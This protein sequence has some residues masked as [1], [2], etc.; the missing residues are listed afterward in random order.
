MVTIFILF[1]A[2]GLVYLLFHRYTN[3]S[4]KFFITIQRSSKTCHPIPKLF[5]NR[6]E[7]TQL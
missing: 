3:A 5:K 6:G 2:I 4:E 7:V 1:D